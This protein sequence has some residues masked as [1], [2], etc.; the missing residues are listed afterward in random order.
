MTGMMANPGVVL[1]PTIQQEA[2]RIV[3]E[4]NKQWAEIIGI[5]PAARVTAIKPEGTGSLS[6]GVLANGIHPAHAHWMLRR[7]RMNK[8]EAPFQHFAKHNPHMI[9]DAIGSSVDAIVTFPIRVSK[10]TMVKSDLD[11]LS[12]LEIIKS[13]QANWVV[14][15][16]TDKNTRNVHHNV[17]CTVIVKENEWSNV[18]DYLYFNRAFFSAVSLLADGGDKKYKQAPYEAIDPYSD[19]FDDFINLIRDMKPVDYR[20]MQEWDDNTELGQEASCVGGACEI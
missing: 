1:D 19:S 13:T 8:Q 18:I 16:T 3:V 7:V 10:E 12:H 20:L 2:A 4:I 17:S 6:L 9:E 5:N 15:G 14:P 11:A